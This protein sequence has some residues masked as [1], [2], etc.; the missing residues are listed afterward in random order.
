MAA[1]GC[2]SHP[3]KIRSVW[4]THGKDWFVG[5]KNAEYLGDGFFPKSAVKLSFSHNR[6]EHTPPSV[7]HINAPNK[8]VDV[9]SVRSSP[10]QGLRAVVADKHEPP[11][12][13]PRRRSDAA[14]TTRPADSRKHD[15]REIRREPRAATYGRSFQQPVF[16]I[17][18]LKTAGGG[19]GGIICSQPT[20]TN[21]ERDATSSRAAETSQRDNHLGLRLLFPV[22]SVKP[23]QRL[24][25][26][27]RKPST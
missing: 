14:S 10:P 23:Q 21:E 16:L 3:I 19:G 18:L 27:G 20:D 25:P 1:K 4:E 8:N 11:H 12:I 2:S 6:Q 24:Y 17:E 22:V 9:L 15:R 5:S 13:S 26:A 7:T